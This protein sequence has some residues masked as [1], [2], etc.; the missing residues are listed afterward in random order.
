MATEPPAQDRPDDAFPAARFTALI[1][2]L[3]RYARLA[4]GLAGEP[5]LSRT[6]RA[7]LVGAAAYLVSPVD[8]VPGIVPVVGQVDD[9]AIA[10]LALRAALRALDEPTRTR[11]LA[12]A[13][14]GPADL[15]EDTR[16]LGLV[17]L[18]LGRRGA[19]L[20]RRLVALAGVAAAHAARTGGR[21][22]V[23]AGEAGARTGA[24]A[25]G[26]IARATGRRVRDGAAAGGSAA[27]STAGRIGR[28]VGRRLPRRRPVDDE[29]PG[30]SA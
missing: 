23:R 25:T 10:L 18:W 5:R 28:G 22:A 21:L 19:R 8:L 1:K 20:G 24:G 16:T 11:Q 7:A 2:R 14:L 4:W 12:A 6:R 15:D 27:R 29:P 17:A 9:V 30:G 26:R 13:G 3:P